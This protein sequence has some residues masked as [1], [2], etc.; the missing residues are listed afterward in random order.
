MQRST[1]ASLSRLRGNVLSKSRPSAV[2]TTFYAIQCQSAATHA[3]PRHLSR[4]HPMMNGTPLKPVNARPDHCNFST[5]PTE[6]EMSPIISGPDHEIPPVHLMQR[7]SEHGSR[8]FMRDGNRT[9]SYSDLHHFARE[10]SFQLQPFVEQGRSIPPPSHA[11]ATTPLPPRIAYLVP[12]SFEYAVTTLAA[13]QAG[14]V[15]VPLHTAHP[16]AE[17]QYILQDSGACALVYHPT[18]ADKAAELATLMD[19]PILPCAMGTPRDVAAVETFSVDI[20]SQHIDSNFIRSFAPVHTPLFSSPNTKLPALDG[21]TPSEPAMHVPAFIHEVPLRSPA[22][23]APA[24]FIYTSGTTG[25]PKAVVVT[26][27]ALH[28]QITAQVQQ[29]GWTPEDHIL[30]VLPLHHIHGVVNVVM[31]SMWVGARLTTSK[32]DPVRIWK[33]ITDGVDA[34]VTSDNIPAMKH[35]GT[36]YN[37]PSTTLPKPKPSALTLFMAVPTIYSK[38]IDEFDAQP[39]LQAQRSAACAQFR[40]MVSGSMALPATTM[41]KWRQVSGHT[42]LE[43][44]GMTELGMALTNPYL[45]KRV[46][47]AVGKPM[48]GVQIRLLAQ[49]TEGGDA[50]AAAQSSEFVAGP[51]E[52]LVRGPN[53]FQEYYNKRTA[54]LGTFLPGEAQ[55]YKTAMPHSSQWFQTRGDW[56][57]TGDVAAVDKEGNVHLMGRA[58]VDILKVSGYKVSFI[59][60][61][62][63]ICNS[64]FSATE[65]TSLP[66]IPI[67]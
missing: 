24:L 55:E 19:I 31:T 10:F 3:V 65:S 51:G 33:M 4:H 9:Y 64:P 23:S 67:L 58:S 7:V 36:N 17:L 63:S 40:L 12:S 32:F 49:Q 62:L 39:A 29:W 61:L 1:L 25:K 16:I 14:A 57:L 47:G 30:N 41:Q 22:L 54:T 53:V 15:C 20:G 6:N 35:A 56:F 66:L 21:T 59:L 5:T 28:A 45:G 26:H 46:E 52:L 2:T 43:R 37:P 48:A 27:S 18:F 8:P 34:E 11:E 13:W 60:C 50:N 44:Y 42:L 38:L